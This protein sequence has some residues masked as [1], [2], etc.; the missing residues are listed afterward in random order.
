M[1]AQVARPTYDL[2]QRTIRTI[3][4]ALG[5]DEV[6]RESLHSP[7]SP[8]PVGELVRW[9]GGPLDSMVYIGV[10]VPPIGLDSHMVFA[11]AE[12]SSSYPHFTLDSVAA[13]DHLAFHLDLMS[14]VELAVNHSYMDEV[15]SPLSES[16][17]AGRAIDGLT[18]A[19]LSPRQIAL[20]SPWMLAFRATPEAFVAIEAH[21]D[22][23]V[24]H[25]LGVMSGA[26]PALVETGDELAAHDRR[27]R[28]NLFN[29]DIDPVWAQMDRLLGIDASQKL[30]R[31][32]IE[33]FTPSI[34]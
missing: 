7:M 34:S 2:C 6:Q 12:R 19:H 11:F 1:T 24:R 20:M 4:D 33:H 14:R 29:P 3:V 9:I 22:S 27:H 8:H 16:F 15:F 5:L 21:V 26:A 10:Q 23:Y 30:Q 28:V 13:G 18:P 32:L 25:W 17:E 31:E